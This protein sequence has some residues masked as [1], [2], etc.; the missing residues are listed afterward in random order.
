MLCL[1]ETVVELRLHK[2]AL[3]DNHSQL[4]RPFEVLTQEPRRGCEKSI[5]K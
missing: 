2:L 5:P 1:R 4:P 3:V